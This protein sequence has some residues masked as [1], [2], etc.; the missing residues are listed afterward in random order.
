MDVQHIQLNIPLSFRQVIDIVMQLSPS[1]KQ[2][3]GEVL[4][5]E[6]NDDDVF[7]AEE[8]KQIVRD[9]IKK[10]ENSPYSYLSWNDIERKM[11][12]R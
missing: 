6:Q 7:I 8:H 9:R 3:L 11:A 10:L 5:A 1:E 4:W 12:S 2:Q